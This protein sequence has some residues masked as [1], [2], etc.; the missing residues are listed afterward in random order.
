MSTFND[1][2]Y[3][4]STKR[5]RSSNGRE[6]ATPSATTS[7]SSSDVFTTEHKVD[8]K[9]RGKLLYNQGQ[10]NGCVVWL[11]GLSG[12]GK[13]T[14]SMAVEEELV[15]RGIHCYC[16]DGDNLRNGLC[17][18]LGTIATKFSQ[19]PLFVHDFFPFPGFSE[20]DREEN[21]RRAAET[22]QL[23]GDCGFIVLCSFVSPFEKDRRNARNLATKKG[24]KFFEVHVSTPIEECQRRD[25]KGLY[26]RAMKGEIKNFTGVQ[27]KYEAPTS[28]ELAL[29]TVNRSVDACVED[30]V[31]LLKNG[32]S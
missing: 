4:P 17:K 10:F 8:S 3:E 5:S 29:N 18:D 13:S 6:S 26:A 20:A 25:T 11:T 14:I 27:Q 19:K 21:I 9:R 12:A 22:A 24:L 1:S 30:V 23:F 32:V 31:N 15:S 7:A 16:L 2:I 28:P